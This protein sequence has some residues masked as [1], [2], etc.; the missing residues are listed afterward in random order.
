MNGTQADKTFIMPIRKASTTDFTRLLALNE[1]SVQYLSPLTHERLQALHTQ[2]AYHRVFERNGEVAAFLLAFRE[3]AAYDSPN[4]RWFASRYPQ[5][6]Y[7]DRVVVDERY[8]GLGLGSQLYDDVIAFC[9][10]KHIKLL[11]CEYDVEPPNPQSA[12]FHAKH[13]FEPVGEQMVAGGK[14]RVSLQAL[15]L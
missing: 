2:A 11:T 8:Q 6:L 14:K 4:Y 9:Q 12:A 5:F 1:A 13:G 10:Q 3:G 7:I 15:E